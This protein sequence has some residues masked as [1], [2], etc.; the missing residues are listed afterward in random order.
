MGQQDKSSR[1]ASAIA[2]VL[3]LLGFILSIVSLGWQ[4]RT[5][6]EGLVEK[7]LVR[8]SISFDIPMRDFPIGEDESWI[9]RKKADLAVEV[10]NIGQHPLYVKSVRLIGAVSRSGG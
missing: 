3:G 8:L 6:D 9:R 10:V 1:I 7:A 5:H 4:I 2:S